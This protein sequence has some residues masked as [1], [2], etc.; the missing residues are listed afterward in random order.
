MGRGASPPLC[1]MAV[2]A[3]EAV[4]WLAVPCSLGIPSYSRPANIPASPEGEAAPTK[5]EIVLVGELSA[6]LALQSP[7]ARAYRVRNARTSTHAR[8][9]PAVPRH[10]LPRTS[11]FSARCAHA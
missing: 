6:I 5:P 10:S 9:Q 11:H 8:I 1:P 3:A 7:K 4:P 2:R